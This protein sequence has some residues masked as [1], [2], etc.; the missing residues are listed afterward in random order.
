MLS[1]PAVLLWGVNALVAM[2]IAMAKDRSAAGWLL[3]AL[4]AGPLAVVV[5]LCLPSTG[6][7]A[8]VRL[9]PEAMELCDSCFEP[10][11]RDRHACRYCGAVQFAKAMPR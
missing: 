9:E 6:H 1:E 5:L 11:R 2:T 10:V 3:L 4:L 8:A 7:Y